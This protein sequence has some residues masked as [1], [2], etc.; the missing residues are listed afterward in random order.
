MC[1]PFLPEQKS[2]RTL[3]S[4]FNG[5]IFHQRLTCILNKI[6][7]HHFSDLIITALK[8]TLDKTSAISLSF[9]SMNFFH[10]INLSLNS[11]HLILLHPPYE[12]KFYF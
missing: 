3:W 4:I 2:T 1:T 12:N 10:S 5:V 9:S 6:V 11:K 7:Q 8:Y